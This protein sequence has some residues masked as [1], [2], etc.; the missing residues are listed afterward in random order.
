MTCV[1]SDFDGGVMS[2]TAAVTPLL[3][4]GECM[5]G[6]RHY[7]RGDLIYAHEHMRAYRGRESSFLRISILL[8][9][10][11]TVLN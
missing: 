7:P 10:R 4:N 2:V 6:E 11:G 3:T 1:P 8:R 9:L 5:Y